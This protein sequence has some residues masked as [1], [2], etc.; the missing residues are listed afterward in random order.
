MNCELPNRYYYNFL[1]FEIAQLF[2]ESL[3]FILWILWVSV[4]VKFGFLE[5]LQD[6]LKE[7]ILSDLFDPR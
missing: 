5:P 7:H 1:N 6:S 2:K 4:S 3:N